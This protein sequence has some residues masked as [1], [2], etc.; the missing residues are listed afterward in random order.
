MTGLWTVWPTRKGGEDMTCFNNI[1]TCRRVAAWILAAVTALTPICSVPAYA[2]SGPAGDLENTEY[3]AATWAT[4]TDDVLEYDEVPDLVHSF[5]STITAQYDILDRTKEDFKNAI[6]ELQFAKWDSK[7]LEETAEDNGNTAD[8]ITAATSQIILSAVITSLSSTVNN[9]PSRT[10]QASL[11]KAENTISMYAQSALISYD[12]LRATR[13]TLTQMKELYDRQYQILVRQQELGMATSTEVLEA[14]VNKLSA[15][16]N[17]QAVDSGISQLMNTL[18]P[19]L[20]YD[21]NDPPTIAPIP[22]VDVSQIEELDL[23]YDT[24]K[25]IG[26]N[27]TLQDQRHSDKGRTDGEIK[28]RL[29][30]IN[31]GDARMTIKMQELYNDVLAKQAAFEGAQAGF[32]SAK[33]SAASYQKMY[34]LGMLSETEYIAYM[35]S[36]YNEKASYDSADTGLLLALETYRWAKLGLVDPD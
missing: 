21:P 1:R 18:C 19:L 9:L 13:E 32:E 23:Q 36:Y 10:T 5:N 20:G 15:E 28:S 8:L 31:D 33:L 4:L 34:D 22:A 24:S 25:A 7:R 6:N 3:S 30:L 16:S 35:L 27:S 26:N 29:A 2:A 17:L 14:Q 12:S 11:T